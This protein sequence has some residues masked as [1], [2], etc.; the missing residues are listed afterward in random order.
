MDLRLA[1]TPAEGDNPE[2]VSP[3]LMAL[4]EEIAET[5]EVV[6]E[7][8]HDQLPVGAKG[9]ATVAALVAHV[10]L[11][12]VK[13]IIAILQAWEARTGRTV[14]VSLDGDTLKITRASREQQDRVIGAWLARHP[15]GP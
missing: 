9:V 1:V 3:W 5:R 15:A 10:P 14:E 2:D 7:P 4:W 11:T 6:I 12:G 13:A 8:E